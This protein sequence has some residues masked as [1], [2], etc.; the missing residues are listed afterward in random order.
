MFLI[1]GG[2][3]F[4]VSEPR[5]IKLFLVVSILGK[6]DHITGAVRRLVEISSLLSR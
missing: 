4:Q 2:R 1:S 6:G 3:L 5:Y